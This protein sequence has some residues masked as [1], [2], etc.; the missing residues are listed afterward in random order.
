MSSFWWKSEI[1]NCRK[2]YLIAKYAANVIEL[3]G[4]RK[5]AATKDIFKANCEED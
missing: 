4:V 3:A 1:E 5:A 2:V